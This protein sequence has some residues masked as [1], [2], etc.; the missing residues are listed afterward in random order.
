MKRLF[1]LRWLRG[2]APG[3]LLIVAGILAR[4]AVPVH[5]QEPLRTAFITDA[6]PKGPTLHDVPP[7]VDPATELTEEARQL[8]GPLTPEDAQRQESLRTIAK[9]IALI[10]EGCEKFGKVPVY[11]AQ[12]RKLERIDGELHDEQL[13]SAKIQHA[14]FSVY[15]KWIE[16]DKNRQ[17]IFVENK[18]EDRLLVQ[19]GGIAGRVTGVLKLDPDSEMARSDSR[20]SIREAGL[21]NLAS[22]VLSFQRVDIQR[23]QGCFSQMREEDEDPSGRATYHFTTTYDSPEFNALYRKAEV[24]VDR[25]LLVPTCVRNFTWAVDVDEATLDEDTLIEFYQWSEIEVGEVDEAAFDPKN[26]NYRMKM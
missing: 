17:L 1:F 3:P 19:P 4:L 22:M 2:Q 24:Y 9:S 18:F 15:M 14:P 7:P 12:F 23:G 13:I 5:S 11:S 16:G 6:N 21:L 8:A 26:K 10:T 25:E 20:Y